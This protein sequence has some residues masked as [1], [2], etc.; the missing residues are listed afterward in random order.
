MT[1]T[2]LLVVAAAA[3]V[4]VAA[5]AQAPTAPAPKPTAPAQTPA[6][7]GNV[8]NGGLLYKKVGC[9]QCHANEAQGGLSGPR[10]GPNVVPYTRFSQYIRNPTGEM[11][12]YTM[13][14]LPDQDLADIYAWVNARPRPPAVNTLP[15]LAP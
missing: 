6:P 3:L 5:A 10:I 11:P 7:A 9:Y 13:K 14:V 15:Q 8:A 1:K 2:V 12:P 4:A